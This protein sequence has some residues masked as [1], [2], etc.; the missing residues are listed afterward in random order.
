MSWFYRLFKKPEN[1]TYV[2]IPTAGFQVTTGVATFAGGIGGNTTLTGITTQRWATVSNTAT[3]NKLMAGTSPLYLGQTGTLGIFFGSAEPWSA[4][5]TGAAKGSLY[6]N[7]SGTAYI[8]TDY[9]S[10]SWS[11]LSAT[12]S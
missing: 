1:D 5:V 6:L 4:G 10:T 3:I 11:T 2:E 9:A 8:K 7:T 12:T